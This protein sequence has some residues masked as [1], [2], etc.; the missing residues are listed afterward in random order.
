MDF[1]KIANELPGFK[2]KWKLHQGIEEIYKSYKEVGMNEEKF[3]G[4]Y[5][6][7]LKQLEHLSHDDLINDSLYWK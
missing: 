5:F 3:N 1:S 7:R 6:N 4:R 2:P